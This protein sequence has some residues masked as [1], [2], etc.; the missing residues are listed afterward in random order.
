MENKKSPNIF[1]VIIAFIL[2]SALIKL[3][4]FGNLEFEKPALAILYIIVFVF[5][6]YLLIRDYIGKP[7]K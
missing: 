5:M 7:K 1:F 2:G 6:I 4:D 3:F